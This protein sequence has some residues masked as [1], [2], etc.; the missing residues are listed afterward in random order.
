MKI[1]VPLVLLMFALIS[2]S[3][4]DARVVMLKQRLATVFPAEMIPDEI[5]PSE[6]AGFYEAQINGHI[7]YISED[8]RYLINGEVLDLQQQKNLTKTRLSDK[9]RQLL[10]S[11]DEDDMII[12]G[13]ESYR[14]T[15]TVFTDIDCGYC[16][17]LHS[18]MKQY[19]GLGIRIRYLAYP[20]AGINSPS[21]KKAEAVW[22]AE[23]RQK[24]LSLA[25]TGQQPVYRACD[26]PVAEQ[27]Q[28]GGQFGVQG[29]PAI[30]LDN[31]ELVPGYVPPADLLRM[32]QS[33]GLR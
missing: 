27:Y 20:R 21:F 15:V 10:A 9:R 26:N 24:A 19:N 33:K 8:G 6:M 7:F 30:V 14:Y 22:C 5:R 17:K 31:G 13:G 28:L 2:G 23:D 11:L 12:Y 32:I 29:T 3:Y 1:K 25:K 4:A 16:R 18:Q